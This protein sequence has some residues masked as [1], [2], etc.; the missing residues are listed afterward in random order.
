M[1]KML[2]L[3]VAT[4][5]NGDKRWADKP[6]AAVIKLIVPPQDLQINVPSH[7]AFLLKQQSADKLFTDLSFVHD[8]CEESEFLLLLF[9]LR[10]KPKFLRQI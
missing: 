5:S 7:G 10:W 3:L 6:L 8:F 4:R 2:S 1:I 9:R